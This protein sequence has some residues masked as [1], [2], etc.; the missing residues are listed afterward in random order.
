MTPPERAAWATALG[1]VGIVAVLGA[2]WLPLLPNRAGWLGPDYAYWLPNLLAGYYWHLQSPWWAMP[3]FSPAECGGVPLHAN[4]QGAY[5][6]LPQLLVGWLGP[7]GGL[8]AAFLAYAGAG[9]WAAWFLARVRFRLGRAESVLAAG[10]F[11]F[12]GLF[13]VRLVVGHLSF[14]P[15]MLLPAMAACVVGAAGVRPADKVLRLCGLGALLAVCVQ[16]GTAVLLPP[17][18][19]GLLTVCVLHG[20][21]AGGVLRASLARLAAGTALALL[22]CA[23]K[24]AAV[25][26]LL[27][28]VPRDSYPLPGFTNLA[29]TAWVAAR[30]VFLW[31]VPAMPAALALSALTLELHEFDYRV[32]PVPL[33]LLAAWAWAAWRG[34]DA[35]QAVMT[36]RRRLLCYALVGLLAVPVALNTLL[37]GWTPF[38]KALPIIGSSSSLLRWFAAFILPACL[39]G[40]IALDRLAARLPGGGRGAWGI[41]GAG[42]AATALLVALPDRSFYGPHG[43][44]V[45][46]PAP[47]AAGFAAAR[48]SGTVPPVTGLVQAAGVS[49]AGQDG[50]T[51]GLSQIT[52]YE[53]L[54]GYRQER[55]PKGVLHAGGVFE[56]A[57]AR[58]LRLNLVDPACYVFPGAN[59]C[60]PGAAF[61]ASDLPAARAFAGYRP[62]VFAKPGWARLADWVGLATL[63]GLGV[64]TVWAGAVRLRGR[65]RTA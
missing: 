9:C 19:L 45:Y 12:N 43:I 3:W 40:A 2:I 63:A 46:D 56:V 42:I 7:V 18:M 39:G 62:W 10:L 55:L 14:G 21:A 31:P 11:T 61:A 36:L 25:A 8:R 37:P 54:F 52:C 20:L 29:E 38:L 4:P 1:L 41:T 57:D 13:A 48:A 30:G 34:G 59:G 51:R 58:G 23:G 35:R 49:L 16:A 6:S 50:L 17:M 26:S 53:P 24:L 32:G 33:V 44:G 60:A 65:G 64:A 28:H 5:L 22:L 15:F 47:I 27:A